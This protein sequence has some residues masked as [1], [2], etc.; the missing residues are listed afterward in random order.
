MSKLVDSWDGKFNS[1]MYSHADVMELL[2]H[3]RKCEEMLRKLE[4]SG[5]DCIGDYC[6]F[7]YEYE[8]DGH[9]PDC[10]L[11]KLIK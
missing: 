11:A 2:A 3:T 9:S 8:K 6:S 7:C 5:S 1:I 10:E 4:W